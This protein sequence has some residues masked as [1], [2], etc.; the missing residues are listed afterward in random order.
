MSGR[1]RHR[2]FPAHGERHALNCF[3]QLDYLKFERC[4]GQGHFS[5]VYQGRYHQ[6]TPVAIKVI[7]RGSD[8][9]V[10]REIRILNTLRGVPN[11]V[12]LYEVI[13]D[14]N[15]LL[16]FELLEGLDSVE[17]FEHLTLKRL[18]KLL[19]AVLEALKAAHAKGIAHRDVKLG[20]IVVTNHFREIKLIDWGCG[21]FVTGD[22]SSRAGSRQCRPPEML[23]GYKNYGY[24]C[25]MWAVGVLIIYILSGGEIPWRARTSDDTLIR[26]STYFG[27]NAIDDIAGKLH[28]RIDEELDDAFCDDPEEDLESCFSDD[29]DDLWD[30]DLIDLMKKLLNIDPDARL[31]AEEALNHKFFQ[32]S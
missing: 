10:S 9:L 28:I 23:L 8:R 1:R 24:K 18:K 29:F 12:Q 32:N 17:V 5:H 20:N 22:M 25:D 19:K 30:T 4:I 26:M 11:I 27:G 16:V 6:G 31:T 3:P 2:R 21:I 14:R 7:E 15:T 13:E